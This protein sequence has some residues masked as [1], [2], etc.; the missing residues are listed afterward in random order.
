MA[1]VKGKLYVVRHGVVSRDYRSS[2][3]CAWPKCLNRVGFGVAGLGTDLYVVGGVIWPPANQEP[4]YLDDVD[5][6]NVESRREENLVW[7]KGARM[8]LSK[9]TVFGCTVLQL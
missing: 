6:C 5:I 2:P 8:P 1:V 3:L 7:R 9:G 4:E